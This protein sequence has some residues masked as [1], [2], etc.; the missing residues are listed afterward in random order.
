MGCQLEYQVSRGS[1]EALSVEGQPVATLA[2]AQQGMA[3]GDSL[4]TDKRWQRV[5]DT[6]LDNIIAVSG[7]DGPSN[8]GRLC[9]KGR[10]GFDYPRHPERLIR[11]LIRRDGVAKGLDANF[12]PA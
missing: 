11:P 4:K 6:R 1:G 12:D 2:D 8:H 7:R 5:A 3:D 9:V 10:F